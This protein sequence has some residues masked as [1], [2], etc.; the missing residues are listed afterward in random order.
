MLLSRCCCDFVLRFTRYIRV[1]T[2]DSLSLNCLVQYRLCFTESRAAIKSLAW[3]PFNPE[4]LVTGAGTTDRCLRYYNTTS[5]SL[6]STVNTG[7][8]VSSVHWSRSHQELV[9]THGF[10][11]NCATVW[12]FPSMRAITTLNGHKERI[13][14]SALSPDGST[15][16]S[17]SADETLRF[18]RIW[19]PLT[20]S[21]TLSLSSSNSSAAA[22]SDVRGRV[23][24]AAAAAAAAALP[25]GGSALGAKAAAGGMR[26]RTGELA[27]FSGTEADAELKRLYSTARPG[28]GHENTSSLSGLR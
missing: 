15:L 13:I 18:W 20:P 3:C 9:T 10:L 25:G 16:C 27:T 19:D 8:Q 14:T 28:L 26:A 1:H 21:T 12:Q 11:S 23:S 17:A 24:V 5:G 4:L 7:S 6:L 2:S 22:S